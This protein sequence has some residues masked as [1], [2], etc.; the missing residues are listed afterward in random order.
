[1]ATLSRIKITISQPLFAPLK[2][3]LTLTTRR[4]TI[5][6]LARKRQD[7]SA[8]G[9][10]SDILDAQH[11]HLEVRLCIRL[12]QRQLEIAEITRKST[13][14]CPRGLIR[15]TGKRL[16]R[17]RRGSIASKR[18]IAGEAHNPGGGPLC[19]RFGVVG[20]VHDTWRRVLRRAGLARVGESLARD[21]VRAH[22][23][24]QLGRAKSLC[25]KELEESRGVLLGRGQQALGWLLGRVRAA[26]KGLNARA[27]GADDGGNVGAELDEVG[28]ADAVGLVGLEPGRRAGGDGF[29]APVL[30]PGE[31]AREEDGAIS[32]TGRQAGV[33][34]AGVVEAE[35]DGPAGEVGALVA[36][37]EGAGH[38]GGDVAP[39]AALVF[40]ACFRVLGTGGC[41]CGTIP[42]GGALSSE[43]G[44]DWRG[45]HDDVSLHN[46]C[47]SSE[48][49]ESPHLRK[50]F[51]GR[52]RGEGHGKEGG[53]H[54]GC[55]D[56]DEGY[57]QD[58]RE[59][60]EATESR[61]DISG[62]STCRP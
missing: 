50:T 18:N 55:W 15:G 13:Y 11:A 34:C 17:R 59:K 37:G 31:L 3:V 49:S 8:V 53:P 57:T 40:A 58:C 10:T 39:Y 4:P 32:A 42:Y 52:K 22:Q 26:D 7:G 61:R 56:G 5:L 16:P 20:R 30:G 48:L 54:N 41:V 47:P 62:T 27:L 43:D 38:V 33:P 23:G 9:K 2:H 28:H 24:D 21:R 12:R 19:R 29:E 1:M 36:V 35:A 14:C 45:S 6:N 51:G 44:V 46:I 60:E 25:A